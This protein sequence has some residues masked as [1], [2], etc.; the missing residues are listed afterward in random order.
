[1]SKLNAELLFKYSYSLSNQVVIYEQLI[2]SL[3]KKQLINICMIQTC[4]RII[5]KV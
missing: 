4:A 3:S 2:D 1:M 5:V